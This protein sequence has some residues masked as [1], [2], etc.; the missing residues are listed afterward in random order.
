MLP[1]LTPRRQP[2]P[3]VRSFCLPGSLT[4]SG[5]G[6]LLVET[7]SSGHGRGNDTDPAMLVACRGARARGLRPAST[8]TPAA[9]APTSTNGAA[10]TGAPHRL[11]QRSHREP[12]GLA[13]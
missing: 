9:S 11:H 1:E 10:T 2:V 13:A 5:V 8:A 6:C 12:R 3:T 4:G 7:A